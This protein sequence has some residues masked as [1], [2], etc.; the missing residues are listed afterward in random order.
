M[1]VLPLRKKTAVYQRTI[2]LCVYVHVAFR[3][4]SIT[5]NKA[6]HGL[7]RGDGHDDYTS[8]DGF[9][10]TAE[11]ELGQITRVIHA[12]TLIENDIH[13]VLAQD[14]QRASLEDFGQRL[15]RQQLATR[16]DELDR[17]RRVVR[18]D[19][20]CE[21]NTHGTCKAKKQFTS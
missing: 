14:P 11:D 20:A 6:S 16:V 19:F 18:S 21:L 10:V 13:T 3:V 2:I 1:L 4:H 7:R 17:V 8:S 5:R 15:A 12:W 9:P